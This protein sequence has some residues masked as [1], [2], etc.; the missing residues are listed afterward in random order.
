[1]EISTQFRFDSFAEGESSRLAYAAC[2]AIAEDSEI[3][4]NPLVLLG[5]TGMGKT[6]LL[7]SIAN[8]LLSKNSGLKLICATAL[9]FYEEFS[10]NMQLKRENNPTAMREMAAKYRN[11][12]ILILDDFQN[13]ESKTHSQHELLQ[14]FN[15]LLLANKPI[16]AA[17]QV[18]I[19]NMENLNESLRSRLTSGLIVQITPLTLVDRLAI[20]RKKFDMNMI[21]YKIDE[22]VLLH[23]AERTSGTASDLVGIVSNIKFKVMQSN[24]KP[25]LE[26]V[27]EIL[28]EHFSNSHRTLTMETIVK[29]VAENY[30]ISIEILKLKGRGGK[31]AVLARQVAMYFIRNQLKKSFEYIGKYFNRDHS[32]ALYACKTVEEKMKKEMPFNL[33][34]KRIMKSLY[35]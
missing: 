10:K 19:S 8:I 28:E 27:E 21:G 16:I 20:L 30:G 2:K 22:G 14:I 25:D 15:T 24:K 13:I 9:E 23:L 4:G 1:M 34:I 18:P 35:E 31:E 26:M 32:T 33:N 11:I 7:H 6:H 17:S 3:H 29:I 12:D 5:G